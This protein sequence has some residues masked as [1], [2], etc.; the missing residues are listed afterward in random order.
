M[1]EFSIQ[2]YSVE[3][4]QE[5]VALANVQ[6]FDITVGNDHQNVNGKSFMGLFCLDQDQP[7]QVRVDCTEEELSCFQESV[8]RFCI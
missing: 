5:F 3:D 4:V 2:L 6:P 1:R 7:Q 8:K